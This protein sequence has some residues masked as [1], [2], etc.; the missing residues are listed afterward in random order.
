VAVV[1]IEHVPIG[2]IFVAVV[3]VLAVQR[4]ADKLKC[5]GHTDDKRNQSTFKDELPPI[6]FAGEFPQSS[7][8]SFGFLFRS[9]TSVVK[10]R[11]TIA[12]VNRAPGTVFV[13]VNI[14]TAA[15]HDSSLETER[16]SMRLR[17]LL[18]LL[19]VE[20][21][22]LDFRG[23]GLFPSDV[24]LRRLSIGINSVS[25]RYLDTNA[26]DN[27]SVAFRNAGTSAESRCS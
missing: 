10:F 14:P 18:P 13:F 20:A 15:K 24:S 16:S 27:P 22:R 2:F 3:V 1:L 26:S 9:V 21:A 5:H 11:R 6:R 7:C 25:A 8:C 4:L 12:V 23:R 19:Q 17:L